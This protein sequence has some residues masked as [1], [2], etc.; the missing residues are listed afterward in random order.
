MG[1]LT[2]IEMFNKAVLNPNETSIAYICPFI[3][4]IRKLLER[5]RKI[6]TINAATRLNIWH[7]NGKKKKN[8]HIP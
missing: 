3:S 2:V 4:I 8:S 5:N 1:L 6:S 7:Q